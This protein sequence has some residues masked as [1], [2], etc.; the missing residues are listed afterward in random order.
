VDTSMS[1]RSRPSSET[2]SPARCASRPR[3]Q[4]LGALEI[5]EGC[6]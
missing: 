3:R 2:R 1:T 6:C 5:L 4:A